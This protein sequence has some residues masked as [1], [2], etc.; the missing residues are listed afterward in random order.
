MIAAQDVSSGTTTTLE[1]IT[2]RLARRSRSHT[3]PKQ[4]PTATPPPIN[5]KYPVPDAASSRDDVTRSAPSTA[6][7]ILFTPI[8]ESLDAMERGFAALRHGKLGDPPRGHHR[9]RDNWRASTLRG[10]KWTMNMLAGQ[11]MVVNNFL[12]FIASCLGLIIAV[13]S[14]FGY[15]RL[16]LF[17]QNR[18]M[19]GTGGGGGGGG[20]MQQVVPQATTTTTTTTTTTITTTT[21]TITTTTITATDAPAAASTSTTVNNFYYCTFARDVEITGPGSGVGEGFYV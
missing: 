3:D 11:N 21:T 15:P 7:E 14:I 18:G 16:P 4:R 6:S 8:P 9:R 1:A 10:L 2:P 5:E 19:G 13:S 20:S 17:G 12:V